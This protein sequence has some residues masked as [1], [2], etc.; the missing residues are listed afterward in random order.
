MIT[1]AEEMCESGYDEIKLTDF[2]KEITQSTYMNLTTERE[3]Y[4]IP[5]HPGCIWIYKQISAL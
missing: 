5:H 4:I 1:K 3:E 2:T